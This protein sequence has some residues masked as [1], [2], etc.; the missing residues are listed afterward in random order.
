VELN[1]V[2]L[3]LAADGFAEPSEYYLVSVDPKRDTPAR[4]AE[5]VAYFD[6]ELRG[7]TG[8]PTALA[9]LAQAADT[10]FDVPEDSGADNYLVSH[11]S[12]VVLLDPN[13]RV[14]AVFSAPHDPPRFAEDFAKVVARYNGHE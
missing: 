6:P 4:L 10:L 12:N 14:H 1:K 2:K 7:L 3:E 5:Y 9:A 13:G 11:S 8:S